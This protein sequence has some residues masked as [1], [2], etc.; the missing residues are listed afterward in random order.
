MNEEIAV[1]ILGIILSAIGT[2][3]WKWVSNIENK[4]NSI[5]DIVHN[6]SPTISDHVERLNTIETKV[7]QLIHRES[8]TN[9]KVTHLIQFINKEF[10]RI[11]ALSTELQE[12]KKVNSRTS[13]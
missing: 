8:E 10:Y 1:A 7:D 6:Y 9:E 13:K 12:C 4:L 2:M 3:V 5:Q 11:N